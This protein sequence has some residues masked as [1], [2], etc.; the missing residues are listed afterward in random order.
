MLHFFVVGL[1]DLPW[2]FL[3]LEDVPG[4][5]V[6]GGNRGADGRAD[7]FADAD[8]LFCNRL[9]LYLLQH[10]GLCGE[11]HRHIGRDLRAEIAGGEVDAVQ[12]GF[13]VELVD[14]RVGQSGFGVLHH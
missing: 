12:V 14:D 8:T 13:A 2:L 1:L 7:G 9:V 3:A 10:D 5:I 4:E 6:P 11:L